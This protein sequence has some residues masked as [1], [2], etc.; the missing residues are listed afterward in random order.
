MDKTY[1]SFQANISKTRFTFNTIVI[2]KNVILC[3]KTAKPN[4]QNYFRQ[5]STTLVK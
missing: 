5:N 2:I 1:G 3:H 4:E